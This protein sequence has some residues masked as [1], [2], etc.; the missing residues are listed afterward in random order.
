MHVATKLL[1]KNFEGIV[2]VCSH[3]RISK[4]EFSIK[5]AKVF[6]F[7]PEQI[8]PVQ[9]YRLKNKVKRP[10]DLSLSDTKLCKIL[11]ISGITI[12]STLKALR[13]D[14]EKFS[15]IR[16]LGKT[17]PYGKHYIDQ[18][19]IKAVTKTLS[20]GALTQGPEIQRF[21]EAIAEYTGAKYAVAVSSATAGL[22]LSYLSLGLDAHKKY[23]NVT[24][25]FCLNSKCCAFLQGTRKVCRY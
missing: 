22:H 23:L 10:F 19:D 4:Y 13:A 1:E 3:E 20:S 17:M 25:N 7:D 18:S 12:D 14:K 16:N 9:A 24:N 6:G 2:N 5:L 21:E 8:Q 15:E 11:N